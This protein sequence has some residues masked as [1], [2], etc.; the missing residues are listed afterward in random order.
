MKQRSR[1]L[2]VAT[3]TIL[4]CAANHPAS[5]Q[6]PDTTPSADRPARVALLLDQLRQPTSTFDP[7]SIARYMRIRDSVTEEVFAEI[8]AFVTEHFI[9]GQTDEAQVKDG[10]DELL[11]HLPRHSLEATAAFVV[12]LSTGRYLVTCIDIP[13]IGDGPDDAMWLRAYRDDGG[14]FVR[15]AEAEFAQDRRRGPGNDGGLTTLQLTGLEPLSATRFWFVATAVRH[16]GALGSVVLR[17]VRFDGETFTTVAAAPDVFPA[18]SPTVEPLPDGGFTVQRRAS[19]YGKRIV[20]R[21]AMTE[22]GP[23][24]VEEWDAESR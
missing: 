21:Y 22:Q 13:R 23:V 24:K 2:A 5:A 8:D 17:I 16:Q 11:H 20:E 12:S 7:P 4:L 14:R 19:R 9:P 3:L 1:R 15:V 18:A 6:Q 10:V